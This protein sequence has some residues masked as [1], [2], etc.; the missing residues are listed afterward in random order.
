MRYH[1]ALD[2]THQD[3]SD[4]NERLEIL[5]SPRRS[6]RGRARFNLDLGVSAYRLE[7]TRDLNNGYYDPRRYEHYALTASPY[8]K[9]HENVG[10]GAD[11]SPAVPQRD[12]TSVAFHVRRNHRRRSDV[13]AS[14]PRGC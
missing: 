12:T 7:T 13:R 3:L 9:L 11:R 4:G 5:V 10:L 8:F 1:V 2:V 14:T 6:S